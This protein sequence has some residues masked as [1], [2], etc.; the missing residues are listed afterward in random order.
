[1][2]VEMNDV[3]FADTIL[4]EADEYGLKAEVTVFALNAMKNNP[5]LTIEA[6]LLAGYQ[7]WIK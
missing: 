7:E 4:E 1:M 6:A 2:I 5:E 3:E